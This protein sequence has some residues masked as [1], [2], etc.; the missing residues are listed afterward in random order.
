MNRLINEKRFYSLLGL[1]AKAG[2]IKSGEFQT[3]EAVKKYRAAL[4][5][6]ADD[7]SNNTKKQFKDM[8]S[9]YDVP[10]IICGSKDELGH[11][12]GREMRASLAVTDEGFSKSILKIAFAAD[13]RED[14][15]E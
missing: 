14:N 6:V 3:E 15:K 12:I 13:I 1:A 7:A 8:C 4:V 5:I 2:K 10:I 11:S 9:Y